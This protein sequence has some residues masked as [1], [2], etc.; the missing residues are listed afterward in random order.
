V[1]FQH[2]GIDV[3]GVFLLVALGFEHFKADGGGVAVG[4]VETLK[5]VAALVPHAKQQGDDD[6]DPE[7][8]A[9]GEAQHAI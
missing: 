1:G 5:V 2:A 8:V 3:A 4:D 9:D 7:E 6:G